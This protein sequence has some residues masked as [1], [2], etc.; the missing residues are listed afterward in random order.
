MKKILIKILKKKMEMY[1]LYEKD[2]PKITQKSDN[3]NSI[4]EWGASNRPAP[5]VYK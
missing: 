4:I 1:L 5:P 2:T 3:K